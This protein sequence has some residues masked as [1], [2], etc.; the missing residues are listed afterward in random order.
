MAFQVVEDSLRDIFLSSLFQGATA[1]ITGREITGL[2]FKWA[3]IALPNPTWTKG[4]NWTASCMITGHLVAALCRTAD[5]RSGDHGVLMGERREEIWWGHVEETQTS[6]GEAL[7]AALKIDVRRLGWIQRTGVLLSVLPST[8]NWMKLGAQKLRDSLFLNYRINPPYLPSHCNGCGVVFS[9]CHALD[10]KKCGLIMS[11]HNE[12]HDGF[13]ELAGKSFTPVHMHD[14][15][16]IF[17]GRALQGGGE[18]QSNM[19]GQGGNAAGGGGVEGWPANL[20]SLNSGDGQYS[21]HM[22]REYWCHL[23]PVQNPGEMLVDHR[24]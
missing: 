24:T 23:L 11:R 15:P 21:W 2:P 8:V 5:F 19:E 3:G 16:K 10:Y 20:G 6:L 17:I 4:V 9:I 7:T 13:A 18:S 22:C 1:Q 12:L 14:H